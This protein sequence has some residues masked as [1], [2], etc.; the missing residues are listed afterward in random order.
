MTASTARRKGRN[1][2]QTKKATKKKPA[3][4]QRLLTRGLQTTDHYIALCQALI[5][6]ITGGKVTKREAL[7]SVRKANKWLLAWSKKGGW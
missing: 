6:D 4:S 1:A 2:R 3:R 5:S 7:Q